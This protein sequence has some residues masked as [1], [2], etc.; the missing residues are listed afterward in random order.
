MLLIQFIL[1]LFSCFRRLAFL[2]TEYCAMAHVRL[3]WNELAWV[4][5][6]KFM[7][8]WAAFLCS[9]LW[10]ILPQCA[11][12]TTKV[13]NAVDIRKWLRLGRWIW[14]LFFFLFVGKFL[15]GWQNFFYNF[16]SFKFL[17]KSK[18]L[19]I[20]KKKLKHQN[21]KKIQNLIFFLNLKF[22]KNPTFQNSINFLNLKFS[23]IQNFF[24][25]Q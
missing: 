24:K 23:K 4:W 25:I 18:L 15:V 13:L 10:L 17:K 9:L 7:T 11:V 14:V 12:H 19:K 22:S 20:P 21:F 3:F 2:H 8:N 16:L 5:L 1:R 6:I